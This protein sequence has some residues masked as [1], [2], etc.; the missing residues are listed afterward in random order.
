MAWEATAEL[1]AG[2]RGH[3]RLGERAKHAMVG[4]VGRAKFEAK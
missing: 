3:K 4:D 2:K 1:W